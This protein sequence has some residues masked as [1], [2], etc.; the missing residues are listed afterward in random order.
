MKQIMILAIALLSTIGCSQSK[1]KI[2]KEAVK[3]T[4]F[5]Y[6]DALNESS[7]EKVLL[8]YTEN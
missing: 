7:S 2:T 5:N 3:K 8:L 1:E 4:L 6:R